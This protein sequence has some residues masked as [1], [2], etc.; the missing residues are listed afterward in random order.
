MIR[1]HSG[2]GEPQRVLLLTAYFD[3]FSGYNEV[4][5]A[6]YLSKIAQVTVYS[7]DRV[8]PIFSDGMLERDGRR[9]RYLR[10]FDA[11]GEVAVERFPSVCFLN[12]VWSWRLLFR[13]VR[14]REFDRVIMFGPGALFPLPGIFAKGA[15]HVTVFPDNRAMWSHLTPLQK[16]IRAHLF[17]I[18][19]GAWYRLMM[20]RSEWCYAYTPD[21]QS[22][23][24]PYACGDVALMPLCFD[25]DQF[26]YAE[27]VRKAGRE[28]L[29]LNADALMILVPGKLE[30]TKNVE[31]VVEIFDEVARS[32]DRIHLV[33]TGVD[34]SD[35]AKRFS[36]TVRLSASSS[37]IH[38]VPFVSPEE[39]NTLMNAA[40][41]A[42]WPS[43]PAITIQQALATGLRVVL[44]DHGTV[45]HLLKNDQGV[46]FDESSKPDLL[47][48]MRRELDN[49]V[50]GQEARLKR[51]AA[52]SWMAADRIAARLLSPS[53]AGERL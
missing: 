34:E 8:S 40:D 19:K 38:L 51:A 15:V 9:R 30:A 53:S 28:S 45:S 39:L 31:L 1:R 27:G 5:V 13:L 52:A 43:K 12:L 17:G 18:T 24:A 36:S 37:R 20:S 42:V 23:I 50:G 49:V 16:R 25:P 3:A 44:P 29:S 22:T 4:T 46:Y 35:Y 14:C 33:V 32:D 21:G 48:T 7:S 47:R 2:R 10:R 26:F 11:F 41:L 6:K